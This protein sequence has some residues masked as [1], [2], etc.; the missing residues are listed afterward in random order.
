MLAYILSFRGF[1]LG[2]LNTDE[3]AKWDLSKFN[4]DELNLVNFYRD[5]PQYIHSNGQ[6]IVDTVANN[7]N[8]LM[9]YIA[10]SQDFV[11]KLENI[12]DNVVYSEVKNAINSLLDHFNSLTEEEQTALHNDYND[13]IA[14]DVESEI[15]VED[16]Q[17][18]NILK[19]LSETIS[20][21]V[22]V[23]AINFMI[24][25]YDAMTQEEQATF[26]QE[27]AATIQAFIALSGIN[28]ETTDTLGNTDDMNFTE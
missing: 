13:A 15:V 23:N 8:T 21:P 7:L 5:N 12:R 11:V 24:K 9:L 25:E 10:G 20:F 26:S 2:E 18:I 16:N 6:F 14:D 19:M 4:E 22:M 1:S 3:F 27:S 28:E 17:F